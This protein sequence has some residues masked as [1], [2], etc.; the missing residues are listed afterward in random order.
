MKQKTPL[1]KK[2][3]AALVLFGLMGQVAWVIEN[4]YLN[5]FIYE[6]FNAS[7]ADISAM[8]AASAVTATASRY[9]CNTPTCTQAVTSA[10]ASSSARTGSPLHARPWQIAGKDKRPTRSCGACLDSNP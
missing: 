4:M 10:C 1:S 3:W 8:V 6:M 9:G 5:V 7:P 2:F